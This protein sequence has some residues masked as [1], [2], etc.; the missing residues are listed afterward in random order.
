MFYDIRLQH[1]WLMEVVFP[2]TLDSEWP[3]GLLKFAT[4]LVL[5]CCNGGNFNL[6]SR[7]LY[8]GYLHMHTLHKYLQKFVRDLAEQSVDVI[9]GLG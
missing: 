9:T 8:P 5:D 6:M 3:L 4:S 1:F 2:P 7:I